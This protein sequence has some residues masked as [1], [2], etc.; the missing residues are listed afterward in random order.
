[1]Q[2]P[3]IH[4]CHTWVRILQS[5]KKKTW[6]DC[7]YAPVFPPNYC[8]PG[9]ADHFSRCIPASWDPFSKWGIFPPFGAFFHH[10]CFR[11]RQKICQHYPSTTLTHLITMNQQ[12]GFDPWLQQGEGFFQF[13]QDNTW[14]NLSVPVSDMCARHALRSLDMSSI[15]CPPFYKRWPNGH[16]HENTDKPY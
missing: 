6:W 7:L 14:V 15:S 12:P 16:L 13:F 11:F 8:M 4:C 5:S 1:M 2:A 10:L 3:S 9:L